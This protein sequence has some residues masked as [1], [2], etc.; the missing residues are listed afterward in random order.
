[1]KKSK[2]KQLRT[3]AKCEHQG[4][5]NSVAGLFMVVR[6]NAFWDANIGHP[7]DYLITESEFLWYH[8]K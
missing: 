2:M 1:M 3:I 8:T 5:H 7:H 6:S 4:I